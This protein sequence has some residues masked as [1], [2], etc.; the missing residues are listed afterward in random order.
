MR[1]VQQQGSYQRQPS[2]A[3]LTFGGV[4]G[5]GVFLPDAAG[6]ANAKNLKDGS[7]AAPVT[8]THQLIG[9]YLQLR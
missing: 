6:P 9:T 8:T 2:N 4:S 5:P 7:V 1:L 3:I